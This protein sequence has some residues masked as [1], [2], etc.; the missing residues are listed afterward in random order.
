MSRLRVEPRVTESAIAQYLVPVV[1]IVLTLLSGT[2]LFSF[3]GKAPSA[4]LYTFLIEPMT[5]RFGI[6]EVLLKMAPLLLIAQGLAIG[7]PESINDI[8]VPQTVAIEDE[9]FDSVISE[10]TRMV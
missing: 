3:L 5:T 2:I 10:T 4:V 7:T 6:G 8:E 1:A 9:P